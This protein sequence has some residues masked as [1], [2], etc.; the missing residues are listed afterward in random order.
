[1]R[2]IRAKQFLLQKIHS[3]AFIF[4]PLFLIGN[5]KE[6]ANPCSLSNEVLNDLHRLDSLISIPE[7]RRQDKDW[8][9]NNYKEPSLLDAKTETYRFIWRSS[10]DTNK[11]GKIEK[12]DGHYSVTT[13]IFTSHQDTIGTTSKF[14]I[15][16]REWNNIVNGL[17][18]NGFWTYPISDNRNGLDGSTWTLEGYKPEKDKCTGMNYHRIGRWSPTDTTFIEMCELIHKVDKAK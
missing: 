14:D 15:T 4:I 2:H 6:P 17:V 11:V 12:I 7:L 9:E 3:I 18:R 16:E 5:C 10:F 13:K 1:M 8:L